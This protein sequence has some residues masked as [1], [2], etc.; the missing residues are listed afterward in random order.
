ML[1]LSDISEEAILERVDEYSLYCFYLGYAPIVGAKANSVLRDKDDKASFGVFE[2]KRGNPEDPHEFLWK[3]QGLPYP[4]F[5]DIFD[6]VKVI[7]K[8]TRWEAII[9]V[10]EDFGLMQGSTN[11]PKTLIHIPVKKRPC[12]LSFKERPFTLSDYKYWEQFHISKATL[13]HFQVKAVSYYFL[14]KEKDNAFKPVGNMYAYK[15]QS[16][17]QLYQ[18]NPKL[19]IM[20]WTDSCIPGF[21]QLR[22]NEVCII[23]KSYKDVM[24]LWQLGF[25]A[26]SPR[27]ENQYPSP[28]FLEWLQWK[29]KGKVFTLF[30]N[31]G[32]TSEDRYPF[33]STY[34]PKDSG[35]KDPTDFSRKF[36]LEATFKLIKTMQEDFLLLESVL[37]HRF[38][39][40]S[41]SFMYKGTKEI[42]W[43]ERLSIEYSLTV[44][45]QIILFTHNKR[46]ELPLDN[47][48]KTVHVIT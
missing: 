13:D 3:D 46:F 32:K 8:L 41:I 35:E 42:I 33:V 18:P 31:D 48:L 9:K 26:V 38:Q 28:L 20:D 27:G 2:R 45:P 12:E 40:I 25:D 23:T 37:T 30:D 24:L 17:Y 6:L 43:L 34:I 21:E 11:V 29:Y 44:E 7:F 15:I 5:G 22:G 36:G 47:F 16:R 10:A 19:F 1:S 4:N 39:R 14:Y